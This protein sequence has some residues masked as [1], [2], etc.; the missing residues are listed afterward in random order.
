MPGFR[1]GMRTR[2]HEAILGFAFSLLP[3]FWPID[4]I[5]LSGP[6]HMLAGD[7]LIAHWCIPDEVG[8]EIGV[9]GV[10]WSALVKY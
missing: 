1:R 8:V 7:P 10:L 9:D 5:K 4:K 6:F 3:P 2:I